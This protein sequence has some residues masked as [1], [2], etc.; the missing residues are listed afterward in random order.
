MS[1][2]AQSVERG[3]PAG[4]QRREIEYDAGT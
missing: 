2:A 3:A 1:V 4:D